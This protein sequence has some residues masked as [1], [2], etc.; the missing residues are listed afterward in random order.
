MMTRISA[1]MALVGRL[2]GRRPLER[3]RRRRENKIKRNLQ[4]V[5]WDMGWTDLAQ[6]GSCEC[7]NEPAV[8][9]QCGEFLD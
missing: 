4:E 3:P 1:Y 5:R 7:G 8:S 6:A 9:I 2:E